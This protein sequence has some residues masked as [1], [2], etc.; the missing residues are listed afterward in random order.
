MIMSY[1]CGF[2][3]KCTR[4]LINIKNR[5]FLNRSILGHSI[6]LK[7]KMIESASLGKVEPD[8]CEDSKI[9]LKWL[10]N[11]LEYQMAAV[12]FPQITRTGALRTTN[13]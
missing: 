3:L 9:I 7:W 4:D 11:N 8:G 5:I 1:Y 2:A 13:R 10:L 6:P 12:F